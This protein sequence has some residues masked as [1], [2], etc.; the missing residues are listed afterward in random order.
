MSVQKQPKL[1]EIAARIS[2]HLNRFECDP[3]IN[4]RRNGEDR[5]T[6]IYYLARARMAGSRVM[7]IY[8]NYQG[9]IGLSKDEALAY[10]AWLDAGNAGKHYEAL[11]KVAVGE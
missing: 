2:V 9:W 4:V 1:A 10:L 5:G 11:R 7:V 3:V 8:V 6:T